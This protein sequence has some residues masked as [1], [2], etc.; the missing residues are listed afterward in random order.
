MQ[1]YQSLFLTL[2][3][4]TLIYLSIEKFRHLTLNDEAI[5]TKITKITSDADQLAYKIKDIKN[6]AQEVKNELQGYRQDDA[7]VISN[8][9]LLEED[10]NTHKGE[11]VVK[12][13]DMFDRIDKLN[14]KVEELE[15]AAAGASSENDN[16]KKKKDREKGREEKKRTMKYD[17]PPP[18]NEKEVQQAIQ[19]Q[20]P[21]VE[22]LRGQP[23]QFS[24]Q[25][26][27]DPYEARLL[28]S[29][30]IIHKIWNFDASKTYPLQPNRKKVLIVA[31]WRGGSTLTSQLFN[32]L[33]DSA[34]IFEPLQARNQEHLDN[35][36]RDLL[37]NDDANDRAQYQ[38]LLQKMEED[39]GEILSSYF[40]CEFPD[41]GK[42]L[43]E[44]FLLALN[45][46]RSDIIP[47]M[48]KCVRYG[49]CYPEDTREF[50]V[51]PFCPSD[52]VWSFDKSCAHSYQIK[53]M[54]NKY[55]PN[56]CRYQN[57]ISMKV[58][59]FDDPNVIIRNTNLYNDPNFKMIYVMR[60]PR[61]LLASRFKMVRAMRNHPIDSS[62]FANA[63]LQNRYT[64]LIDFIENLKKMNIDPKEK[65][66]VMRYE[67]FALDTNGYVDKIYNF[68][69]IDI[70]NDQQ[71]IENYNYVKEQLFAD[72][73]GEKDQKAFSYGTGQRDAIKTVT[74]WI[75]SLNWDIVEQ[76][77]KDFGGPEMFEITGY[78]YFYS[79]AEYQRAKA[80]A[81]KRDDVIVEKWFGEE[82]S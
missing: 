24:P 81:D 79:Q 56:M 55:W 46:V 73:N 57:I 52:D 35:I 4:F 5:V 1:H 32:Y 69:G 30:K 7:G 39:Q 33:P 27:L 75:D 82:L 43:T 77:Q 72:T 54:L 62:R 60:D 38:D 53:E 25:Q 16:E 26:N 66:F 10:F 13:L 70:E 20:A 21:V 80:D 34:Y 59:R 11:Y 14:S 22:P 29:Q 63:Q 18:E 36:Y 78:K 61:G 23:K 3:G 2:L 49:L 41:L 8:I 17:P 51:E 44:E 64:L 76:I 71:N 42:Y 28:N 19:I 67:D 45:E 6:D 31:Q 58:I 40:N 37:T 9:E 68:V 15:V 12:M 65:V 50:H 47:K 74:S 48:R